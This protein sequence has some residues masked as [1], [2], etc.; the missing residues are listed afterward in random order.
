MIEV[1]YNS[2]DT[3]ETDD[4]TSIYTITDLINVSSLDDNNRQPEYSDEPVNNSNTQKS[5]HLIKKLINLN[6]KIGDNI[7]SFLSVFGNFMILFPLFG[8]FLCLTRTFWRL[9]CRLWLV[10]SILLIM[11]F[12]G[13][14]ALAHPSNSYTVTS[15]DINLIISN[16]VYNRETGT[17]TVNVKNNGSNYSY[18]Y[19]TSIAT[20]KGFI[21]FAKTRVKC[22]GPSVGQAPGN[23]KKVKFY[24]SMPK[25][26]KVSSYS[27]D[28]HNNN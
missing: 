4:G 20:K 24:C 14:G 1:Q 6:N 13:K 22:D 3:E 25:L 27:F 16:P 11:L 15:G 17:I 8:R 19:L 5:N 12:V 7:Y 26:E 10:V 23:S 2:E 9:I 18:Y 21:P 28:I